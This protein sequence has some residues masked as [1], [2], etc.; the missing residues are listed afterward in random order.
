[1]PDNLARLG[2]LIDTD[3]PGVPDETNGHDNPDGS[4]ALDDL[5]GPSRAKDL[6]GLGRVGSTNLTAMTGSYGLSG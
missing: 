1:M 5:V 4:D 6:D 2:W 3:L